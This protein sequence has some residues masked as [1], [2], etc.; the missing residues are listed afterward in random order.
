[1]IRGGLWSDLATLRD[2]AVATSKVNEICM[3]G[4]NG[5]G[6]PPNPNPQ[7]G[8][9]AIGGNNDIGVF[10]Y[11]YDSEF[12][13]RMD[14][15]LGCLTDAEADAELINPLT[16]PLPIC[17]SKRGRPHSI[18]E[19]TEASQRSGTFAYAAPQGPNYACTGNSRDPRTRTAC[20]SN[21]DCCQGYGCTGK[22][23]SIAH[24]IYGIS[25]NLIPYASWCVDLALA[26]G[27][28]TTISPS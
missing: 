23:S 14:P 3:G 10:V 24:I 19:T 13:K 27:M 15:E 22:S 16:D 4:A 8:V 17:G 9:Q 21:A 7:G 26:A 5:R 11:S 12:G 2:V 18:G 20:L 25:Q 6:G 28:Q 1:M